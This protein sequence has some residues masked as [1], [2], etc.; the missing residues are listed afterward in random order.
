MQGKAI[1]RNVSMTRGSE[2]K[3]STLGFVTQRAE[4]SAST[5]PSSTYSAICYKI[6][7]AVSLSLLFFKSV[8]S[9]VIRQSLN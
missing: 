3:T 7:L 4:R 1:K 6:L 9:L 2:Q 5:L 8:I